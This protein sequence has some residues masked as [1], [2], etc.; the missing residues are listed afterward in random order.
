MKLKT[1]T[2]CTLLSAS[3]A[4]AVHAQETLQ[5]PSATETQYQ[6]DDLQSQKES[7][8]QSAD[9]IRTTY[10]TQLYT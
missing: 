10:E 1:I 4:I 5:E 9:L 7:F 8:K 2:L 3:F 6:A